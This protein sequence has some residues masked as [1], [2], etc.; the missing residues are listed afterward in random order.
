MRL[1]C[2]KKS[3]IKSEIQKKNSKFGRFF[4]AN[5]VSLGLKGFLSVQELI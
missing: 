2:I 5:M 4:G 1:V 3:E